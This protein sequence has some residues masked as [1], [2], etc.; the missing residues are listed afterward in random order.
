M[1]DATDE[2]QQAIAGEMQLMDPRVRSSRELAGRLL[3]PGFVEVG[4]SGRRW[5]YETTLARLADAPGSAPDG[6]RYEPSC[7]TG[8][9][10]APGVVHLT[11]ETRLGAVRTRRSSIWRRREGAA[12]WRMYYHHATPVAPGTE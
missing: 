2:V 9:R 10:L 7:M 8:V 6:P 12:D 4:R 11:F 5:T 1:D 3:D